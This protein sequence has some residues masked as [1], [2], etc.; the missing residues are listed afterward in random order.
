MTTR[1]SMMV[2]GN[3]ITSKLLTTP[4]H[5]L[6]MPRPSGMTAMVLMSDGFMFVRIL[7][8]VLLALVL[9]C[10]VSNFTASHILSSKANI[11]TLAAGFRGMFYLIYVVYIIELIFH[12]QMFPNPT[13]IRLPLLVVP[14]SLFAMAT[15]KCRVPALY[16][17]TFKANL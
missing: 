14:T 2:F 10:Q 17:R 8:S 6:Y 9:R 4:I 3:S 13:M 12:R 5:M 7:T 15:R 11:V 1:T 16:T